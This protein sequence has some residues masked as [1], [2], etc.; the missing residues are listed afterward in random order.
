MT[1]T[2]PMLERNNGAYNC[3]ALAQFKQ[4]L[5][6]YSTAFRVRMDSSAVVLH[7][8]QVPLVSTSWAGR[9][10][11]GAHAQP[12][13][14]A[15]CGGQCLLGSWGSSRVSQQRA[16]QMPMRRVLGGGR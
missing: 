6:V 16:L 10:C 14:E 1:A 13:A 15:L 7:H 11:G 4:A 8:A 9:L 3:L 2:F 12:A 5:G